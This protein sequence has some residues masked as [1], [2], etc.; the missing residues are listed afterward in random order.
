METYS[1]ISRRARRLFLPW[2]QGGPLARRNARSAFMLAVFGWAIWP[3]TQSALHGDDI[4]NSMRSAALKYTNQSQWQYISSSIAQWVRNQGRLFPVSVIENVLLFSTVH[5]VTMYKFIQWLVLLCLV[6]L[7]GWFV[8]IVVGSKSALPVVAFGL[9]AALQ[10]RNWYDPTFGFGL[11]LQSVALKVFLSAILLYFSINGRRRLLWGSLSVI[12]WAGGLLQYEVVITLLPTL[13][14]VAFLPAKHAPLR[15]LVAVMPHFVISV[16][17]LV[18][19]QLLRHGKVVAPA[20]TT[21]TDFHQVFPTYIRQLSASVPLFAHIWDIT[22]RSVIGATSLVTFSIFT[23]LAVVGVVAMRDEL[24]DDPLRRRKIA[25]LFLIGLNL[26]LGPSIPTSLSIR[27]QSELSWGLGYLPVFLQYLGV[28]LVIA[29]ALLWLGSAV[30]RNL[31]R[32]CLL[33]GTLALCTVSATTNRTLLAENVS[34]QEPARWSREF[35][36][37]SVRLGFFDGVPDGSIIESPFAD[38]NSWVSNYFTTWLGGPED[39]TFV[40]S[41]EDRTSFCEAANCQNRTVFSLETMDLSPDHQGL[42]LKE[43]IPRSTGQGSIGDFGRDASIRVA[44][45]NNYQVPCSAISSVIRGRS[46]SIFDCVGGVTS[47][48]RFGSESRK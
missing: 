5:S 11:L 23:V 7:M 40:R 30:V 41:A 39:L 13:A 16:V 17:F 37:D 19:S 15:R 25:G 22:P 9:L 38:P 8:Q 36:E 48:L 45:P 47:K 26:M 3:V 21:N 4:P 29:S 33:A 43:A 1:R 12:V 31:S 20:Y 14:I 34:A 35:Y 32:R 2:F 44:Q 24:S 42:V 6:V 28:A 27:W 10:T 18:V 46:V